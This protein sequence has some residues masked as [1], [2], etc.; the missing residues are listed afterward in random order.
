M[1]TLGCYGITEWLSIAACRRDFKALS[2]HF[3]LLITSFV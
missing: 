3:G 1:K 2:L